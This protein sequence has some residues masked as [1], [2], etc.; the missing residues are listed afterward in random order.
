MNRSAVPLLFALLALTACARNEERLATVAISPQAEA[1]PWENF[2]RS[3][4]RFNDSLDRNFMAPVTR[5]YRTVVPT[6]PRRGLSNFYSLAREPSHAANATLQAKPK[7]AFRA[8]SR[9]VVNTVLGLGLA[10]HATGMGLT[11]EPHDFGQTLAVWGVPSGPYLYTPFLGPNTT[12]DAFGFL[13][14]FVFDPVDL[15][16]AEV[17]TREQ[18][19]GMLSVRVLDLRSR[20]MD[21]GEQLLIGAADPYATTHAAWL[22]LRRYEIFDG[23]PPLEADD[24]EDDFESSETLSPPL[25]EEQP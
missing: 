15:L 9:I 19:V 25:A 13:V 17:M 1:D 12:R 3:V 16:K 8:L 23:N 2:N 4:Y 24:W 22:Q 18:R 10:D 14:D 11:R 5:G 21:Q 20:L 6:A 7:S